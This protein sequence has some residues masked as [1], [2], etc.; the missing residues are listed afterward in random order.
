MD[1]ELEAEVIARVQVELHLGFDEESDKALLTTWLVAERLLDAGIWVDVIPHNYWVGSDLRLEAMD[2]PKV[3][4]N[5]R[6]MFI[7]R[8][9]TEDELMDA[10]TSRLG[11]SPKRVSAEAALGAGLDED[12]FRDAEAVIIT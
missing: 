1:E 3:V 11:F 12:G 6:V 2:L 9:P 10:I 7:G 5:G 4:I 8:A